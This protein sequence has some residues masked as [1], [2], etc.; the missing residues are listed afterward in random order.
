MGNRTVRLRAPF[1]SWVFHILLCAH[2]NEKSGEIISSVIKSC[3]YGFVNE[4]S[5]NHIL[6]RQNTKEAVNYTTIK[7]P[8]PGGLAQKK[9][10][11]FLF[12]WNRNCTFFS[13]SGLF[14]LMAQIRNAFKPEKMSFITTPEPVIAVLCLKEPSPPH[15]QYNHTTARTKF[16]IKNHGD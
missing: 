15:F 1:V 4:V 8:C 16:L 6:G 14:S 10:R 2:P 9:V 3:L 11:Y 7:C 5:R 12:L 13:I